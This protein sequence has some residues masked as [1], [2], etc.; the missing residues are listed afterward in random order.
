MPTTQELVGPYTYKCRVMPKDR[1]VPKMRAKS[2]RGP[3]FKE[4][5]NPMVLPN[6]KIKILFT[7][8]LVSLPCLCLLDGW[9]VPKGR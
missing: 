2:Q 3:Y 7:S 4:G 1:G 6:M 8:S 5:P 9:K